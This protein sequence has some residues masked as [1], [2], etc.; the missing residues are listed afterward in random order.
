MQGLSPKFVIFFTTT[1]KIFQTKNIWDT[2]MGPVGCKGSALIMNVERCMLWSTGG[3]HVGNEVL[4]FGRILGMC[5]YVC[6]CVHGDF[7][8]GW[9][10]S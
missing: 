7:S 6:V 2:T 10:F 1:K 3:G 8:N 5:V 9:S 4:S